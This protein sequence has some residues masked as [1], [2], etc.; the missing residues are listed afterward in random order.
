MKIEKIF[1]KATRTLEYVKIMNSETET[2]HVDS[3]K[4][5]FLSS[6]GH[7]SSFE[8]HQISLSYRMLQKTKVHFT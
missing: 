7:G 8:V 3:F 4:K 5:L 2:V 1:N 6:R